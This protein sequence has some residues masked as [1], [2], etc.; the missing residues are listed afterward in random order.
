MRL[1]NPEAQIIHDTV[2]TFDPEAKVFLFGS[3]TDDAKKGGDIDLLIISNTIDAAMK[4]EI[5]LKLCDQL[6]EQK[7]DIVLTRDAH[8]PFCVQAIAEGILL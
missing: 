6:G 5:K 3:R 7:I 8:E 2:L 1:K 4:R